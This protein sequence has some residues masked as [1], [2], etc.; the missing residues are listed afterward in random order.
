M[1]TLNMRIRY[2]PIRI[3]WCIRDGNIDDI[4]EALKL[5]HVLWGGRY[6]PLIPVDN[7]KF[8]R[9]L[10]NLFKVD[11]LYAVSDEKTIKSFI[12]KFPYLP[13][14][15]FNRGIFTDSS[16]GK[17]A[18]ILD[19]YH[20][21]R[22]LREEY[23]KEG[24]LSKIKVKL[25]NWENT[26]PLSNV[27][28]ATFG[29]FPTTEISG[30]DYASM[31]EK[32]LETEQTVIDS[33]VD[34]PSE[35]RG[36]ITVNRLTTYNLMGQ[37]SYGWRDSGFYIGD[38]NG[39]PDLV[40][41]WNLRA[42]GIN[43]FFYDP[44]YKER[45]DPLKNNQLEKLRAQPP[46]PR[47]RDKHNSIWSKRENQDKF[48]LTEFGE[49]LLRCAEDE[50]V[51]N[52]LNVKPSIMHFEEKSALGALSTIDTTSVSF[53]LP[54]KPFYGD[55]EFH[56][57]HIM[58]TVHPLTDIS[59]EK[60]TF[61]TPYVP[62]LNEF[63][64]RNFHFSWNETRVEPDGLGIIIDL[65]KSDLTLQAINNR[66]LL[67]KLFEI[68]GIKAEISTPGLKCTN[69]IQQMGGRLQ[70]CRVFKISGVRE[71][72][73]KYS[74]QE[75][76]TKSAAVQIIGQNDASTGTPVFSKY[77]NL[78]IEQRSRTSKLKPED[79]FRYLVSKSVFRVGLKLTCT[80]CQL[81][82][83]KQL[84][85]VK[86]ITTCEY[87]G[88][89]FDISPQLRDRDWAYRR[90]G[91]FGRD[92]HQEGGIP[93]AVTLQQLDTASSIRS[94][95]Y[96]TAMN[97]SPISADIDKCETDFVIV[98][99]DYDGRVSIVIGECKTH[100]EI[101]ED[102]VR[103]LS[104][105]ADAFPRERFDTFILFSK[106]DKYT[107]EEIERC[108]IGQEKYRDRVIMLSIRELEPYDIY[109]ET[110]KL[111]RI[112]RFNTR[113]D[114]LAMNTGNIYFKNLLVQP[115]SKSKSKKFPKP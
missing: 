78:F 61:F 91:V 115:N 89:K 49:G 14:P 26:D 87:C 101:S 10:V 18:T 68:Y 60:I 54:E 46:D 2:R 114:G 8:A 99:Q 66:Q 70:N 41:Y 95:I 25:L 106:L 33:S 92:D 50:G 44:L 64:G 53:Q 38:S 110:E 40:A 79:A 111:Y 34:I 5:T 16:E 75:S 19:L 3:G 37:R 81:N 35:L 65:T 43:L 30:F 83:W 13:W 104:K 80:N 108:K 59:D 52:G 48:D 6:N 55:A 56:Q 86:T 84:D 29:A 22:K 45:L 109:E 94:H 12:K 9:Q 4:Q 90:S 102:D 73:G 32:Y 107:A 77:E 98:Q 105:V 62:E 31:I 28:L 51:W 82:F 15:F 20:T 24:T 71:L 88:A 103:N 113:Y 112:D 76:F 42:S 27:F 23:L 47:G 11:V 72:I 17:V 58:A 69:L 100:K 39:F 36:A 21:V 67:K 85:E 74:A 96:V 1:S 57:Q 93:V 97:L 7:E 63:Y